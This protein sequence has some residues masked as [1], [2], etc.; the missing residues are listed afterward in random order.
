MKTRSLLRSVVAT[1]LV[2]AFVSCL[3]VAQAGAAEKKFTADTNHTIIG[4][5]ASTLLFDVPGHFEKYKV[6]ISGDPDT[7]AD[8]KIKLEI[9]AASIF[10]DNKTRDKH[11]SSDD[12]FDV[13]KYP[14]ITF[15]SSKVTKQGSKVTVDGTLE[16]HGV[17]KDL[18][19]PFESVV[20]KNGAG[21]ME[22]VYKAELTLNRKDFG[23][24]SDSIG[25]K[26]SLSNDVKLKLLLAGFF[27]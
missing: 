15:T 25:A 8:A 17:K 5:T 14:K 21:V 1:G 11:L 10:T 7:A 6:N 16:M 9:D 12:F 18:S 4:F 26:I 24:G 23:I 27:E 19:I 13:K 22:N 3:L 2:S 20:A